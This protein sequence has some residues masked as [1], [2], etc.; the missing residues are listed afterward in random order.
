MREPL[1]A[2]DR[3]FSQEKTYG[4]KEG[5]TGGGDQLTA[6]RRNSK[7]QTDFN[8]NASGSMEGTLTNTLKLPKS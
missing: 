8:L 2:D 3:Q 7:Y 5:L 4:K 1:E 6:K